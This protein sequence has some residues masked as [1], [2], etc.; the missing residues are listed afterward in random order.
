MICWTFFWPK[1]YHKN[2]PLFTG[3][4]PS[5]MLT[6]EALQGRK[7]PKKTAMLDGVR[8][9]GG[10]SSRQALEFLGAYGA[11][12]APLEKPNVTYLARLR[13]GPRSLRAWG[14]CLRLAL[15]FL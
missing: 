8:Y 5:V 15:I 4:P 2:L 11:K 14:D 10:L 3:Q 12:D 6:C 13:Y 9:P 1:H 7:Y